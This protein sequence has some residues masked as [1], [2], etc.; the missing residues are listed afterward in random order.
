MRL[1]K[2]REEIA[3]FVSSGPVS[4]GLS[5]ED[6]FPSGK[7]EETWR[8]IKISSELNKEQNEQVQQLLEE[9]S[10]IFSNIPNRTEVTVHS[11][12]TGQAN[13]IRSTPYRNPQA[14][15][16]LVNDELDR[17]LALGIVRPSTSPWA[18]PV[19]I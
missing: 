3:S 6:G 17:M 18:S 1:W 16:K 15:D 10:D 14:S 9:F 2:T 13:P 19:V 5:H 11:I 4:E 7:K 12:D 8:D